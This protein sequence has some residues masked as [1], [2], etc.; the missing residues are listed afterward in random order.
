MVSNSINPKFNHC[1]TGFVFSAIAAVLFLFSGCDSEEEDSDETIP[2]EDESENVIPENGEEDD[3]TDQDN[4]IAEDE[5]DVP[6]VYGVSA[7]H[8]DAV[9]AGMEVLENGG[10]A[11]DA[12]IAAAFAVSV[13]EPFASGIGG[14]G[15]TL[16]QE[17]G[18]EPE[19]YDYREVVPEAGIPASDTGVPGFVAGMMELHEDYGMA[20]WP[21]LIDPAIHLAE[22]AE[23][24]ATLAQQLQSA[25]GRLPVE[26]LDH[27]YPGGV[28][29]EA[30]ATL[31]Q[32]E[33]AATLR[34]IRDSD[35]ASF[36]EGDIGEALTNIEGL[37]MNS[38][39]DYS[40]GRHHPVSG[41][42]AG[43]EIIG[44]P[45]PLPGASVIQ[46]LQIIEERGTLE[47]ERNSAPFIHDIAMSWRLA[48]QFIE[49]DFGDPYFVD[50]PVEQLTDPERNAAL[51]EEISSDS[52]LS[53]DS[54]RSYQDS[55]PNTTHIT[56]IDDE[57]TVVSMTNTL[58]NFFGSGVY[59]EGFFL[60]NQ[61]VRFSIGQAGQNEPEPG[62]RS[63]TWSSPMIVADEEGPVM[64]LGS[65]G[66]E[67]IPMML[68]QMI[69]DWVGGE[70]DLEGVVEAERFHL[71]DDALIMEGTPGP[72]LSEALLATGYSEIREAP[73]PLYFGSIQA[74]A[75]DRETGELLGAADH[76]READ[77]RMDT[78]D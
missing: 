45:P 28:P 32:T 71:M 15:V 22:S 16:I 44:A 60:N 1:Q 14:G 57:G 8:P 2:S 17:Q 63:V 61:M 25:Q 9:K 23:V 54:Q 69:A 55:D 56:V 49:T 59:T 21:A 19:A 67:R 29:I 66:G 34:E 77:W 20:E 64:G 4:E 42:F 72:N 37:D 39:S 47:E 50:V 35:G 62:R 10:N 46:M 52:L 51:A 48:E 38:L 13:V 53:A 27:F 11:A 3:E 58:T 5:P 6:V 78:R 7:G 33:L 18:E 26:E 75:I 68:T 24:S 74:L 70:T 76:R 65:P 30:G 36:Y 31:K 43:Y 41:E 12:A 40:V 73:T